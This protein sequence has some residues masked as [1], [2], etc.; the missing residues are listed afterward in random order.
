M[1]PDT[2]ESP[3]MSE[4]T[5]AASEALPAPPALVELMLYPER[6]FRDRFP[7]WSASRTVPRM[8]GAVYLLGVANALDRIALT[9]ALGRRE[10]AQNWTSYWLF[11]LGMACVSGPLGYALG[12]LWFRLRLHWCRAET[13]MDT[14]ALVF[15][16]TEWINVLPALIVAVVETIANDTPADAWNDNRLWWLLP[17][18]AGWTL[19]VR[20]VAARVGF[21]AARR[22]ALG[23]FFVAPLALLMLIMGGGVYAGLKGLL[24]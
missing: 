16:V 8:V 9:T 10:M 1:N 7:Q 14:A 13:D 20:Y 23:W 22:R 15:V 11:A 6:F 18:M 19:Y 5:A 21:G 2:S 3:R 17:C 4:P 24:H 12:G